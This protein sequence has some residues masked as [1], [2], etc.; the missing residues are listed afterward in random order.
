MSDEL[1]IQS[2]S[3]ELLR[4]RFHIPVEILFN[5]FESHLQ[6]ENNLRVFFS[7]K[8]GSG[9]TYFL[10]EFFEAN[11]EKYIVIKLYPVSY[12]TASNRD[13]FEL[14]KFDILFHILSNYSHTV[15]KS[16]EI[17]ELLKIQFFISEFINQRKASLLTDVFSIFNEVAVVDPV[18]KLGTTKIL[19]VLSDAF[20]EYEK[21]KKDTLKDDTLESNEYLNRV[22]T[23][24]PEYSFE[25]PI[26]R[27][28]SESIGKLQ[29]ESENQKE[30][31]LL[32]DDM[33]RLDPDHLFRILN[34][35]GN[36]FV[37]SNVSR[38]YRYQN[39]FGFD[40]II[41]VGD[42]NNIRSI[43][44]HRYGVKADFNGYFSKYYSKEEYNFKSLDYIDKEKIEN[45]IPKLKISSELC[46][47]PQVEDKANEMKNI[48]LPYI[49]N[50][51]IKR[52]NSVLRSLYSII[53]SKEIEIHLNKED[54]PLISD[55]DLVYY[56]LSRYFKQMFR[57]NIGLLSDIH[58]NNVPV[59]LEIIIRDT[60]DQDA[61][62]CSAVA[63]NLYYKNDEFKNKY[64]KYVNSS[65]HVDSFFES[66]NMRYQTYSF[67]FT[68]QPSFH[69]KRFAL[70]YNSGV[71]SASINVWELI[72]MSF[73][74]L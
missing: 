71:K 35:F 72:K 31:I 51:L 16:P 25:D 59:S 8:F 17:K 48:I 11:K 28:I 41:T 44:N 53:N 6:I 21:F 19:T 43:F 62:V 63:F 65:Y 9:K 7:A 13:I 68:Y 24:H 47:N 40:K 1:V 52:P 70:S 45:L 4:N 42:I 67:T 58:V 49:I 64:S 36:H 29:T 20:K 30:V 3:N 57:N 32:I 18:T 73:I 46:K 50:I 27:I 23:E 34:V 14:I 74:D 22:L 39:K 55:L 69:K 37:E 66:G 2:E 33:D 38:F 12:S 61:F 5:Q 54:E 60:T 15:E 10:N 26:S 56:S